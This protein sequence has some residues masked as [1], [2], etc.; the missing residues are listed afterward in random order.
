MG[1]VS[2]RHEEPR[3]QRSRSKPP[4]THRQPIPTAEN[5]ASE[6][7]AK[8]GDHRQLRIAQVQALQAQAGNRAVTG[9]FG[10]RGKT[11]DSLPSVQRKIGLELELAVPIDKVGV[12]SDDDVAIYRG[13]KNDRARR[14]EITK[15]VKAGQDA[16]YGEFGQADDKIAL[17]AD[18]SSRVL[19]PDGK[20]SRVFGRSILELVFK[21]PVETM[22]ELKASVAA[23]QGAVTKIDAATVGL[24]KRAKLAGDFHVGPLPGKGKPKELSYD[25]MVHVNLGI[26]PRRLHSLL[27]WYGSSE[28]KP[29]SEHR[30]QP[31]THA[32]D[33]ADQTVNAFIAGAGE[34]ADAADV[35]DWNGLRG[36]TTM[37]VMYLTSGADKSPLASSVKN[38]ATILTKTPFKDIVT[39]GL[40]PEEREWLKSAFAEYKEVLLR[41]T[42]PG[43]SE[44]SPLILRTDPKKPGVRKSDWQ[45]SSI[46]GGG[47]PLI[48]A[49][50]QIPADEV[51]PIRSPADKVT[52]GG[53]RKGMVLEFR[54]LPG[55]YPPDQWQK[56]AEDFLAAA[57]REN[58]VEDY[59]EPAPEP[60]P[61]TRSVPPSPKAAQVAQERRVAEF[62][63]LE[64]PTIE[65]RPAS[66]QPLP[67]GPNRASSS[68]PSQ[69][70]PSL[71]GRSGRPLPTPP[72][73]APVVTI[74]PASITV[75]QNEAFWSN[76][77]QVTWQGR[78]YTVLDRIKPG[79]YRLLPL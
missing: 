27:G 41:A 30:I 79:Q 17:H 32:L 58:A 9:L 75:S 55:K 23:A 61:P 73:S 7:P 42:R 20:P 36:L 70:A 74:P 57:D 39:Y 1:H 35:Q 5:S 66:S 49:E 65:V 12:L 22:P 11:A 40:T 56:V 6:S 62:E 60:S 51:G 15:M 63:A 24:T 78:S 64:L 45:I 48:A 13:E 54:S 31:I 68:A 33:I 19:P 29:R 71:P 16:G 50:K 76:G 14:Q 21:P 18:H 8:V 77:Q 2:G 34:A 72:R 28:Y 43:E 37:F 25:A 3:S 4:S 52:G 26:D 46:F 67:R 69:A 59:Q 47:A 38:F 53:R 10:H 44:D